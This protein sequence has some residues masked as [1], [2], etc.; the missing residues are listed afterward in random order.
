M[1]V[2]TGSHINV[3]PRRDG[4]PVPFDPTNS[5][6]NL[7]WD[8]GKGEYIQEILDLKNPEFRMVITFTE[9]DLIQAKMTG[10]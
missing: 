2:V 6:I 9:D 1:K 7:S 8:S 5:V 10:G 3:G 4:G